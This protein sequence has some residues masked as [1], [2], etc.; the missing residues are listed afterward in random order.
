[1]KRN[2]RDLRELVKIFLSAKFM[3]MIS[4]LDLL[5]S[6]LRGVWQNDVKGI[7]NENDREIELLPWSS[8][9]TIERWNFCEPN[10]VFE[11][12]VQEVWPR[13]CKSNQNS[14]GY[15]WSS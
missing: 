11:G 5:M 8:N 3:L 15:K 1:M 14:Y 12:H 4:F 2:K 10:K 7:S 9:Q 6:C 13:G